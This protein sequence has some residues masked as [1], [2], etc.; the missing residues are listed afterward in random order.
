[1]A[2]SGESMLEMPVPGS[3][4]GTGPNEAAGVGPAEGLGV[5]RI[6]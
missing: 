6:S 2:A 5:R 4:L 1:M 3:Q